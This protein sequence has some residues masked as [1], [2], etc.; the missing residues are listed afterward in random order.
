MS[1]REVGNKWGAAG[2]HLEK[3][4][5]CALMLADDTKLGLIADMCENGADIQSDWCREHKTHPEPYEI[6]GQ[7]VYAV[8]H[9]SGTG[10]GLCW[11]QL[12][13]RNMESW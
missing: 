3:V 5:E 6:Q 10:W 4:I 12:C 11:K 9:C 7:M 8:Y 2:V 13:W 1:Y